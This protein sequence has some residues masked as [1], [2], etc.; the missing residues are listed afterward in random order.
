MAALRRFEPCKFFLGLAEAGA[1]AAKPVKETTWADDIYSAFITALQIVGIILYICVA[2]RIAAFV[3]NDLLYKPVPY[4][5]LGFIYAFIFAPILI[6]YYIY[7]E[8]AHWIWPTMEAPHFESIFPVNPYDPSEPITF[9]K[10][11]FG[12]ADT[13]EIRSWIQKMQEQE[14][15]NH[16]RMASHKPLL[17]NLIGYK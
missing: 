14:L 7:R 2:V 3:A 5:A 17:T 16:I 9:N 8:F 1:E 13:P 4:R 11:V 10:R 6:P 12:Y 15:G